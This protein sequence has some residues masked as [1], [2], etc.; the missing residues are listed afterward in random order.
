MD[1]HSSPDQKMVKVNG[2]RLLLYSWPRSRHCSD[3]SLSPAIILEHGLGGTAIEW[4]EV[5]RLL[6]KF[7][8]VYLCER[9]GYKPCD[10]PQREPTLAS[11]ASDIHELCNVAEIP[12]PY[13]LVGHSYGGMLVRQCLADWPP[14]L[15][16]GMVLIDAAP[17]VLALPSSW[18]S[19]LGPNDTYWQVVG[20][21]TNHTMPSEEYER[22]K[23]DT[24]TN[25]GPES[26]AAYEQ[27]SQD[28]ASSRL[29]KRLKAHHVPLGSRPL[30]VIFCDESTDFSK[31]LE[32]G[33]RN[34][35]GTFEAREDL[36]KRLGDMSAIEEAAQRSLLE[37][38]SN[39]HFVRM[40]GKA[41]TH[42][43]HLVDPHVIVDEIRKVF[44]LAQ[45]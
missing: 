15:I 36:R 28:E 22:I 2:S 12:P 21:D 5:S 38:S 30:S 26:I 1:P 41:K 31:I 29:L 7:A 17:T 6:A 34:N 33:I 3:G 14:D 44:D 27:R 18:S 23:T 10:P 37:L 35:H 42:N 9:A 40:V 11:R 16:K 8:S 13:I 20:L 45:N 19:L 39:S 24:A 4:F 43:A 32:H 25:E